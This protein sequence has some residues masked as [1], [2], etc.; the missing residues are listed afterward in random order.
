MSH[1]QALV[2]VTAQAT[3]SYAQN[4][5]LEGTNSH[6]FESA[7]VPYCDQISQSTIIIVYKFVDDGN[8]WRKY[9]QKQVKDSDI[10][11]TIINV[12]TQNIQSRRKSNVPLMAK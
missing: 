7:V 6:N 10:Q 12:I 1:Q 8:N 4:N 9:E 11:G 2:Q 5:S 3:H